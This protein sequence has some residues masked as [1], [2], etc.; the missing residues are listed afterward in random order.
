MILLILA[1]NT[2]MVG[3]D[4]D[5]L[6][7]SDIGTFNNEFEQNAFPHRFD[8]N[9]WGWSWSA[10]MA[11]NNVLIGVMNINGDQHEEKGDLS[12]DLVF[13]ARI[14]EVGYLLDLYYMLAF[15]KVGG[16]YSHVHLKAYSYSDSTTFFGVLND[17]GESA[18]LTASSFSLSG[19]VGL[20]IPLTD[21][22]AVHLTG[23]YI[24]GLNEPNWKFANGKELYGDPGMDLRHTYI[25]VGVLIGEFGR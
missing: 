21:F 5:Y 17:P 11:Q 15:L 9:S 8:N 2:G 23:G 19:S 16:G 25:K 14:F 18:N 24:H 12:L 20:L 22:M 1:I 4:V 6:I 10:S 7:H 3:L 13:Q